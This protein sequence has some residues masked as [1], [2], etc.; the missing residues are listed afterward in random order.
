MIQHS[1]LNHF[2]PLYFPEAEKYFQSSRLDWFINFL[3]EYPC[4]A[5]I[6][7]LSED[8]FI[9]EAWAVK[10]RKVSKRQLLRDIYSTAK[11]SVA[12]PIDPDSLA[13]KAMKLVLD[14]YQN[15]VRRRSELEDMAHQHLEGQRAYEILR[16]IPGI[17]PVIALTILAEAGDLTRFRHH[18]QFL[19][20]CGLDLSTQQSGQY[21]GRTKLS[22]RGNSRLRTVFWMAATI[23]TRLGQNTFRAKYER[24]IANDPQNPDRKRTAYIAV[25]AKIARVAHSLIKLDQFYRPFPEEAVPGVGIPNSQAMGANRTP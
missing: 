9:K 11:T 16:S 25:A 12:L 5:T 13:I 14:E 4:P 3:K 15:L 1:V 21:R 23:S 17:G 6:V 19:K 18:R 24:L 20:Y 22:K 8:Q 2:L 10:G 7:C